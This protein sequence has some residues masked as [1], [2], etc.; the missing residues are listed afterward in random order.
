M[1]KIVVY[2]TQS[3][4]LE[5]KGDLTHQ[6]IWANRMQMAEIFDVNPQAISKHIHNVYKDNELEKTATSSKMELVQMEAGR[7]VKRSVDYYNLEMII[8]VGYR[9]NTVKG[10]KF[11]QWATQTLKQHIIEGITINQKRLDELGKMVQMIEQSGKIENLQLH[12][13]KGLLDILSH[14][15][16]SFVLLNQYDSHNLQTGKLNENITY[17][18]QYNEAKEAIAELKKQLIAKKEA[19]DLFGR[20]KDNGFKSSLQSIVQTFGGQYLYP[21]IEE[22]AAHLLYFVIKNHSFNDGNKRIGAFLFIWFLEKNKHRF[23]QSG[24]LKINDNALT[25]IALLVAQSAPEEKELMIQLVCHL[26][27]D[28]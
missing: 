23:K 27:K 8:S 1:N 11:R 4:S 24:E 9:V 12:E 22:Q 6:T 28:N 5:L 26:I 20:E 25:A 18:I 19:T 17:E 21:S 10:T 2:Q 14:Y 13:A 3:G 7:E 15:T 16:K